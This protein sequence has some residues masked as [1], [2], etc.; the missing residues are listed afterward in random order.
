MPPRLK[1]RIEIVGDFE[2]LKRAATM[3]RELK[4]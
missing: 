3:L 2:D 4:G 1:A